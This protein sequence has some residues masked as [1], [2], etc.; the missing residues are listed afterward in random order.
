MGPHSM[1]TLAA[2][3]REIK[4]L[5][6]S[7]A[8]LVELPAGD[9]AESSH[10]V[11]MIG[12][13]QAMTITATKTVRELAAELP[14]ATRVFEKLGIDYCC[15]GGKSLH[16]ACADARLTVDDVIRSLEQSENTR[17]AAVSER[18]WTNAPLNELTAHI[19]ANHH[20]Y[21]RQEIPRIQALLAKVGSVHRENHPEIAKIQ[22]N[23]QDLASEL[24]SH[25]FK[26]ENV[27]FPYIDSMQ[28][29]VDR[30]EPVP[31]PFFGTVRNP[32]QMMIMEHGAA[33]EKLREMRDL[34]SGY[35]V[36][37]DVC[38][39]YASVYRALGEFEQDLHQHIHL[40]NNILFPRAVEL[41]RS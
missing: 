20:M 16:D 33:G 37:P 41:E 36:P 9:A 21:V 4:K 34:S 40:E 2:E 38:T 24:T 28:A 7:L 6:A 14:G 30:G 10:P 1:E 3:Q 29:A 22:E 23:F 31:P 39:T 11:P 17:Q 25:M 18:N 13:E 8:M 35:K 5:L 15:G 19:V 32:V 26:E 27:L 12:E